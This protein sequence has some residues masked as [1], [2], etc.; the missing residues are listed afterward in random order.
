MQKNINNCSV[1]WVKNKVYVSKI[2][3]K[4]TVFEFAK[5]VTNTSAIFGIVFMTIFYLNS[6]NLPILKLHF[7]EINATP[8][9]PQLSFNNMFVP[10]V[11]I[12]M[13]TLWCIPGIP[14][15]ECV[16]LQQFGN[17]SEFII[18]REL[19]FSMEV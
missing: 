6:L 5:L 15:V 17:F 7:A 13:I 4:N 3:K 12:K 9:I 11:S 2:G 16:M 10:W 14:L 8:S 1:L 18:I 19:A